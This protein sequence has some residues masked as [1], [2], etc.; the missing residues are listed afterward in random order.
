MIVRPLL[1]RKNDDFK[2]LPRVTLKVGRIADNMLKIVHEI[3][4]SAGEGTL[5]GCR[6]VGER[7]EDLCMPIAKNGE[8]RIQQAWKTPS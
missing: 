7:T 8:N 1:N 4:K 6:G 5:G 2:E 3:L